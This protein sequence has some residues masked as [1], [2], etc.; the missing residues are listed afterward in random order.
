LIDPDQRESYEFEHPDI[1]GQWEKYYRD[2][3]DWQRRSAAE[4]EAEAEQ[5]R[6][7]TIQE[8]LERSRKIWIMGEREKQRRVAQANEAELHVLYGQPG[9]YRCYC[10][11]C[12]ARNHRERFERLDGIEFPTLSEYAE[13]LGMKANEA[14]RRSQEAARKRREEQEREAHEHIRKAEEKAQRVA[15]AE[16]RKRAAT[17][18]MKNERS[19]QAANRARQQQEKDAQLRMARSYIK[20]KIDEVLRERGEDD[21][22]TIEYVIELGWTKKKGTAK[23]LFCGGEIKFYAFVCPEGGAVACGPCKKTL[24]KCIVGK[25]GNG[26]ED[27]KENEVK[28]GVEEEDRVVDGD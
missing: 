28:G 1:H 20:N 21:A 17:E 10:R 14:E 8:E 24:G 9:T 18:K 3:E 16:A 11:G 7:R 22:S 13:Y 25:K 26:D 4:A 2:V 5:A 23:C 27:G 15:Q 19:D 6:N 12:K